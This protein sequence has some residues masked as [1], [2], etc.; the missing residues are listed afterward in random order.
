MILSCWLSAQW[1][2]SAVRQKHER[3]F[4]KYGGKFAKDVCLCCHLSDLHD[5]GSFT[6]LA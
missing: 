4:V 3:Y 1:F 2:S 5:L 6:Y